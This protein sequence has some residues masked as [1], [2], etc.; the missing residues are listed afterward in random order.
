M[1]GGGGGGG[2]MN[3]FSDRR[4]WPLKAHGLWICAVNRANSRILKTQ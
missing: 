2:V 4:I 1:R 3:S